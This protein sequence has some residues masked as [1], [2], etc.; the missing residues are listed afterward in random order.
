MPRI[1]LSARGEPVDFDA[2]LIKQKLA[3]APV[4]I[5]VARRQAF[6]DSKEGRSTRPTPVLD[7]G[8][9]NN[10]V[11]VS[12]RPTVNVIVPT[13]EESIASTQQGVKV[14]VKVKKSTNSTGE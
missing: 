10:E 1:Y 14:D 11:S 9:L 7:G 3:Q 5:D 12:G 4:N 8:P 13:D 6:I 2:L